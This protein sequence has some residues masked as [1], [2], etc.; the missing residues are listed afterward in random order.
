LTVSSEVE[1]LFQQVEESL[2]QEGRKRTTVKGQRV[3]LLRQL[4]LRFGSQVDDEIVWRLGAASSD[5]LLCWSVQVLRKTTLA[6]VLD[7]PPWW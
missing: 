1:R 4:R 6:E 7:I 5:L 3:Y 2:L